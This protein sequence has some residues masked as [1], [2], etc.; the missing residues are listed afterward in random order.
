VKSPFVRSFVT[1]FADVSR[2]IYDRVAPR[3][4]GKGI[5]CIIFALLVFLFFL[6]FIAFAAWEL[7]Q[8]L[9]IPSWGA[10]LIVA[11]S[12][13]LFL[14]IVLSKAKKDFTPKAPMPE[15]RKN[16]SGNDLLLAFL[17]G[18]FGEDD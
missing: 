9:P 10:S 5:V 11:G 6:A 18:L 3:S 7:I 16:I 17:D 2:G 1:L 8:L 13:L 4:G 15:D 12:L 14:I